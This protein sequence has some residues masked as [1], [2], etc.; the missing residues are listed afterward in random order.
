[1]RP[2]RNLFIAEPPAARGYGTLSTPVPEYKY[3]FPSSCI[4]LL[5]RRHAVLDNPRMECAGRLS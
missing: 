3:A 2:I 5:C 4:C 1:V